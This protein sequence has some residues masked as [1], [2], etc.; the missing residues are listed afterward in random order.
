M[1]S[2]WG[3]S[4]M[5]PISFMQRSEA[6]YC[7]KLRPGAPSRTRENNQLYLERKGGIIFSSHFWKCYWM[8]SC[9]SFR[10]RWDMLIW[11]NTDICVYELVTQGSHYGQWRESPENLKGNLLFKSRD[12]NISSI[13]FFFFPANCGVI[14]THLIVKN[15]LTVQ[16]STVRWEKSHS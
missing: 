12:Q 1:T 10:S 5:C 14:L 16:T 9:C 6:H 7:R 15:E 8:W 13:F 3:S 2:F 11:P 4:W